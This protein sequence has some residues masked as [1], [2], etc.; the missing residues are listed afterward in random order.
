MKNTTELDTKLSDIQLDNKMILGLLDSLTDTFNN[1]CSPVNGKEFAT[2][3]DRKMIAYE[4][5]RDRNSIDALLFSLNHFILEQ[6]KQLD[7][8]YDEFV[9]K[10][11]AAERKEGAK[12]E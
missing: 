5:V 11:L 12:H 2:D 4:L 8:V 10:E 3:E 7:S 9:N 1:I 6:D